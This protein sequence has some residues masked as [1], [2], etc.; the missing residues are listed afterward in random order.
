[1]ASSRPQGV[2]RRDW[3]AERAVR[4]A[5]TGAPQA[6][7][8]QVGGP[9]S[10]EPPPR[11]AAPAD[12]RSAFTFAVSDDQRSTFRVDNDQRSTFTVGN[13]ADGAAVR[14]TFTIADDSGSTLGLGATAR[15]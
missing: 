12:Q 5:M 10:Y 1:M 11:F 15:H 4:D 6:R 7:P 3:A 9:L 8:R 14:S 13:S 2:S